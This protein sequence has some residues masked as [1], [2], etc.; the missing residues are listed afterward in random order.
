ML[1]VN[2]PKTS[3]LSVAK[4]DAKGVRVGGYGR[5]KQNIL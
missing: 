3:L 2:A 4:T 1:T 5:T